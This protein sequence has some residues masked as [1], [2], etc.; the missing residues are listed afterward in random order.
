MRHDKLNNY[1]LVIQEEVTKHMQQWYAQ[2]A[3]TTSSVV[4]IEVACFIAINPARFKE[5][6]VDIFE[7]MSHLVTCINIRCILGE[8]AYKDHADEISRIYFQLENNGMD[9]PLCASIPPS[10]ILRIAC[11]LDDALQP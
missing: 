2:P 7:V 10:H 9:S 6:K 11:G 3:L 8:K 4:C 5:E 1:S